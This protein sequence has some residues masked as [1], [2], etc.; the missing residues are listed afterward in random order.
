[1]TSA[2]IRIDEATE[3]CH[4]M[5]GRI[6][7]DI[8]VRAVSIKGPVATAH[9]IRPLYLSQDVDVLADVVD[10]EQAGLAPQRTTYA[11]PYVPAMAWARCPAE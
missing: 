7:N 6:G 9:K 10:L 1:M 5:I 2:Q 11:T 8:G 4:A 3:L